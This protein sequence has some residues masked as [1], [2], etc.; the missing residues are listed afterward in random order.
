MSDA[1]MECTVHAIV[2]S[3]AFAICRLKTHVGSGS[4]VL[5]SQ[6]KQIP[7]VGNHHFVVR[8]TDGA[9]FDSSMTIPLASEETQV[10]IS[11][12]G[13]NGCAD[14]PGLHIQH[15]RTEPK[16]TALDALIEAG[17]KSPILLYIELQS[18]EPQYLMDKK[19]PGN[20]AKWVEQAF[21]SQFG[22]WPRFAWV[23][24]QELMASPDTETCLDRE[25]LIQKIKDTSPDIIHKVRSICRHLA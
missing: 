11:G 20:Y 4:A 25:K 2:A 10:K 12:L 22:M 9:I 1:N 7:G 23:I 5:F 15:C 8:D 16:R 17:N 13:F 14:S 21:G 24:A 18:Y 19:L 3:L 6:D